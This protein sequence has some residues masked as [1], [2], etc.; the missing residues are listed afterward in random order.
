LLARTAVRQR[1]A[2]GTRGRV[3]APAG[4]LNRRCSAGV[5]GSSTGRFAARP[6]AVP[7]RIAPPSKTVARPGAELDGKALAL[8]RQLHTFDDFIDEAA[9]ASSPV[10]A[11][12]ADA[13]DRTTVESAVDAGRRGIIEPTFVGPIAE[14]KAIMAT[15]PGS[16]D[17]PV[18]DAPDAEAASD[19]AVDV[20]VAGGADIL[21]KGHVHTDVLLHPVLSRLRTSRRLSHVFVVELES[22]PKLLSITDA[23]VNIAPDLAEKIEILRNALGLARLIG[24]EEPK[25]A[26]LSAVETVTVEFPSTVDAAALAVMGARDQLPHALIDGPLALDDALSAEASETKGISSA[27]AGRIDIALVPDLVSGNIVV[28]ALEYL[29]GATIGGVV[30]GGTVPI[31]LTSRADPLRSRIASYA[32][33]AVV[34]HRRRAGATVAD[35][36]G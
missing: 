13:T 20:V 15:V 31:V 4:V 12:I 19:H 22:Y 36:S 16:A 7:P 29:A 25:V 1:G 27:V 8:S 14:V 9:S 35:G 34:H 33:A 28:K 6:V 3:E 26:V 2:A 24:I 11:V 32:L 17:C 10:R 21:C 18:I 5:R 30:L 23:A